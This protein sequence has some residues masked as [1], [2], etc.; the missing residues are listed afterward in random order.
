[1]PD[2]HILFLSE[3]FVI[4]ID[5]S[6]ILTKLSLIIDQS[7]LINQLYRPKKSCLQ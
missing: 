1:M 2:N 7:L 5:T 4:I 6:N 3:I